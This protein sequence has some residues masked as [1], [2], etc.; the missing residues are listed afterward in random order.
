[1]AD[2]LGLQ[3]HTSLCVVAEFMQVGGLESKE[4]EWLDDVVQNQNFTFDCEPVD[5]E[6]ELLSARNNL[7]M[8]EDISEPHVFLRTSATGCRS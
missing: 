3:S 8:G 2:L 6:G 1:M 7:G 4:D 5:P